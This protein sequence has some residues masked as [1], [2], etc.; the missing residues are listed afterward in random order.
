MVPGVRILFTAAFGTVLL[1][2]S[3]FAQSTPTALVRHA[4]TLNGSV[5]GSIQQLTPESTTLNG[6]ANVTG[7]LLVPGTP[8]IQLNGNPSYGGPVDGTGAA[9]PTTHKVTLNGG[10][11][12]GHV[13]RRT[14]AVALLTITA[15]A[16]PVGTCSVSLN[17]TSDSPGSFTTLKNLTLN[18]NVGAIAVP[19]GTYGDFTANGSSSFTL[20]VAGATTPA[21]Y[22]FQH[23]TLNCTDR[24][25]T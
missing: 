13:V 3:L 12:L 1:A 17:N 24:K 25:S 8:S 20:G 19:A 21:V 4:P 18:G 23:L 16:A 14:D 9:T 15:P 6:S 5:Q 22:N 2:S 10:A 7:D 11:K